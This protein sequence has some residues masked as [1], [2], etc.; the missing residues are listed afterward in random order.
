MKKRL[1]LIFALVVALGLS[2]PVVRIIYWYHMNPYSAV[3]AVILDRTTWS[4]GYSEKAFKLVKVGFTSDE[5]LKLL[6]KPL[7]IGTYKGEPQ[8]HYTVGPNGKPLSESEGSTHVRQISF[9]K[10]MKVDGIQY[11]YYFD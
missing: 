4:N 6:G 10:D 2:F 11:Y 9:N 1:L 7:Y 8:W 5:V 3:W